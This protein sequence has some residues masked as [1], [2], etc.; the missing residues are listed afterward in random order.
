MNEP[1]GRRAPARHVRWTIAVG[2]PPL[3]K[4]TDVADAIKT[5]F[6]DEFNSDRQCLPM[7]LDGT[8][9]PVEQIRD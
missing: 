3:P 9:G 7:T 6:V 2:S 1:T 5:R 8:A 4:K